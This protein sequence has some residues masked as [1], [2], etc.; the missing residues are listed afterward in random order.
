MDMSSDFSN[1]LSFIDEF[2][3]CL[4]LDKSLNT[5]LSYRNDIE[6]LHKFLTSRNR[7]FLNC[8][9]TDISTYFSEYFVKDQYN[10]VKI[11]EAVSVRRKLSAFRSFFDFLYKK[12]LI[13]LN[14]IEDIDVPKKAH[15]IPFYLTEEEISKLFEYTH[16]L[17]TKDGIRT[18]AILHIIYSCGLR[19]SECISIKISDIVNDN[20]VKKKAVILGKGNKE[21]I[22]FVDKAAQSAIIKYLAI[23]D[24][25][26]PYNKTPYLFCASNK[27]GYVTRQSVFLNLQKIA[28]KV[29][30]SE[31]ISPHKLRHSFATHMYQGGIDLRMLQ[32][33]LGH[34]DISTTEIYTHIK[35]DDIKNTIEKY[36]PVFRK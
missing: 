24:S 12:N 34:S 6:L 22:I 7:G 23:R 18:N 2:L 21:R 4:S 30:I 14:P 28:Y 11:I 9:S 15:N 19:V 5:Y 35:S 1:D 8:E 25:L 33:L 32:I 16:S 36:H 17:N 13:Q 3:S 29:S 31:K 20:D 26:K 10:F 27:N